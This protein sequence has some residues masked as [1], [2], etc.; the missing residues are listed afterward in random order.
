MMLSMAMEMRPDACLLRAVAHLFANAECNAA[1]EGD[2][3]SCR[4]VGQNDVWCL[5][6]LKL[7]GVRLTPVPEKTGPLVAT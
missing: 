2:D 6:Q 5:S 7:C 1:C 3:G 4:R